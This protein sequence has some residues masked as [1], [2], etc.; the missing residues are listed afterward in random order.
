MSNLEQDQKQRFR[1]LLIIDDAEGRRTISLEAATYSMGRDVTNSIVLHSKMVSRQ[2]AILLRVTAPETANFLFRIIDGDLQGKRSTNGLIVNGRRLFSHDLKHGD[3]VIFGGDVKTKYYV[4]SNLSDADFDKFCEATDLSTI[5]SQSINP[6]QTLVPDDADLQNMSEAALVRMASFPEL[7]P[8]PILEMDLQGTVTYLNP[9]AVLQFPEISKVATK[10]PML[11][12]LLKM[13][14]TEH[15]GKSNFFMREVELKER[16]YEQ[17]VHYIVESDLIRSYVSDI[18]ERKRAEEQLRH[19]A[20]REAIINRIVQAMRGTMVTAEVLQITVG[21]LFEALAASH[22]LIVQMHTD[23]EPADHYVSDTAI[24]QQ[25]LIQ[26]NERFLRH[27]QET[28]AQGQQVVFNHSGNATNLDSEIVAICEQCDIQTVLVTPLLY[29]QSYLGSISLYQCRDKAALNQEEQPIRAWTPDERGLVKT[30]ADQ[31]AIA[32]HQAQL[33]QQV[34]DLNTN[35][36][37][38]VEDRTAE[39][40]QKM[41][42]LQ[43]LNSLKDDFLST[44]S[45][46]LRTPMSNIKM[47]IHMLNQ[48]PLEPR[49]QRYIS[50]LDAECSRETELINDLLDLQKLEAGGNPIKMEPISVPLWLPRALEPFHTRAKNRGQTFQ[51]N[52]DQSMPTFYSDRISLDRILAELLNN[53]CKY[54]PQGGEV[55]LSIDYQPSPQPMLCMKVTNQAEIPEEELPRIFDKFYRIPNSDPWKQGGTGLGLALVQRQIEQ[56]KGDISVTSE[57]GK[58]IFLV[59]LPYPALHD[60]G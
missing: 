5:L 11:E 44:V 50:I 24:G 10:H 29:L 56:L 2:H 47:A 22:C 19:K 46:E 15:A 34:Q 53:A 9:A 60:L 32:I 51:I 21:L 31:C 33:Y 20:Q 6:F 59:Q 18:T 39:L 54:T 38:Q 48:F 16:V 1:H 36:A 23:G 26:A 41:L 37:Q 14:Q 57:A 42:E 30:I 58:T 13:V 40:Q 45:H 25:D 28:L 8:S 35:L 7:T 52:Y 55:T 3:V 17:S 12:G 27:S 49:Q 4:V 43:R